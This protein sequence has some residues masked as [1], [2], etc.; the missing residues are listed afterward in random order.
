MIALRSIVAATDLSAPARRAVERAAMLA[1]AADASLT[2]LHVVNEAGLDE[3]RR[4]LEQGVAAGQSLIDD[5]RKRTYDLATEIR[6]AYDIPVDNRTVAGP[7][8]DEIVSV[9]DEEQAGLVVTGTLGGGFLRNQVIGSTAER[10]VRRLQ[11]PVLMVR[12]ATSDQYRRVLVPVDLSDWSAPSVELAA[13]VAPDAYFVLVHAV[14]VPFESKLRLA[15][16]QDKVIDDYRVR[17]RN[18]ALEG[19]HDLASRAGLRDGAWRAVAP[20]SNAPW[21]E[22]IRLAAEQQSALIVIGK[23]GRNAV[24]DLLLGS[25]T[26]RVIGGSFSDILVTSRPVSRTQ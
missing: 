10:V 22:V 15:G 21:I 18:E 3:L 20:D 16:V 19:M 11:R 26:N 1:Q 14:R 23:H 4:W 2:L 5:V 12:N 8:V 17:A 24:Q 25:T 9:A 13:A 7:V 6:L